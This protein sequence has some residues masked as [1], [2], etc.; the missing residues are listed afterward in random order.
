MEKLPLRNGALFL[1]LAW[2]GKRGKTS[3]PPHHLVSRHVLLMA[4]SGIRAIRVWWT[5]ESLVFQQTGGRK[6]DFAISSTCGQ[7][8]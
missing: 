2:P 4:K 1:A 5:V 3:Q 6:N 7:E 8:P